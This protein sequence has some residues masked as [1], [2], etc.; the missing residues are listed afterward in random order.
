MTAPE[1][2]LNHELIVMS[3]TFKLMKEGVVARAALRRIKALETTL[4]ETSDIL[5]VTGN[6][7]LS[8]KL[9]AIAGGKN[10]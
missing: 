6:P 4:N 3:A 9:R 10:G 7:D 8:S 1:L 2:D 5:N